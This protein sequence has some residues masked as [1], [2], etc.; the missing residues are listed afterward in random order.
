MYILACSGTSNTSVVYN[1]MHQYIEGWLIQLNDLVVLAVA[2][3]VKGGLGVRYM[4]HGH[5]FYELLAMYYQPRLPLIWLQG[6]EDAIAPVCRSNF[7][8]SDY[9]ICNAPGM[10]WH[11]SDRGALWQQLIIIK[12]CSQTWVYIIIPLYMF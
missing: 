7:G 9:L 3:R 11:D 5:W 1:R 8:I 2:E 4:Y 12:L 10:C 6:P